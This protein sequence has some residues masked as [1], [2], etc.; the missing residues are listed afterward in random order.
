MCTRPFETIL[1]AFF[2][3]TP[4]PVITIPE[5]RKDI[6]EALRFRFLPRPDPRFIIALCRYLTPD[7]FFFSHPQPIFILA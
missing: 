2:A 6:P 3:G 7:P 5:P 1:R 4:D